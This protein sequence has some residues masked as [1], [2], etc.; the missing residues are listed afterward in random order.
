MSWMRCA[1][2]A[3][4]LAGCGWGRV[5]VEEPEAPKNIY[6]QN[7]DPATEELEVTT[8]APK[9]PMALVG[10]GLDLQLRA[11][12]G[13]QPV[14]L[15]MPLE[16]AAIRIGDVPTLSFPLGNVKVDPIAL[17]VVEQ[18]GWARVIADRAFRDTEGSPVQVFFE[19]HSVG[20]MK[21]NLSG[22]GTTA[23]G[24]VLGRLQIGDRQQEIDFPA[25]FRR[26]DANN[27]TVETSGPVKLD[28]LEFNWQDRLSRLGSKLKAAVASQVEI[29][30]RL[31]LERTEGPLPTFV[32]TPVTVQTMEAVRERIDAEYDD[33]DILRHRMQQGGG[34]EG[35][36]DRIS[37]EDFARMQAAA[38]ARRSGTPILLERDAPEDEEPGIVT[39]DLAQPSG[40]GVQVIRDGKPSP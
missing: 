40:G 27:L 23:T 17:S 35:L 38:A 18:P 14:T 1:V 28:L 31:D 7:S 24:V 13:G 9:E 12:V 29:T 11:T 20:Q 25:I 37:P 21:G 3:C 32:H 5:L 8:A 16:L 33:Y 26:V 15:K 19:V 34:A 4:L 6:D 2:A 36:L 22:P 30:L 39:P 10:K